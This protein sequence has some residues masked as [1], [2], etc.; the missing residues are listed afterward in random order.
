MQQDKAAEFST[1]LAADYS[2]A[3][4]S[5]DLVMKGG[6][7]SGV[8]YPTTMCRLAQK[9]RFRSIGGTSAGALAAALAAAAEHERGNAVG[10]SK[11]YRR[12]AAVPGYLGSGTNLRDLF[13]PSASTAP[14]FNLGMA[15]LEKPSIPAIV[16]AALR[17]YSGLTARAALAGG[18]ALALLL[19]LV[20]YIAFASNDPDPMRR[21]W[22]VGI[23]AVAAVCVSALVF[24]TLAA[25]LIGSRMM[26]AL[27][28][29]VPDNDF[30]FCTGLE[31][32][33]PG[34]PVPLTPWLGDRI[35]YIA[36]RTDVE[37]QPADSTLEPLTFGDLYGT[38]NPSHYPYPTGSPVLDA[39][40]A[41]SARRVN[42]EMVTTDVTAGRPYRLPFDADGVTQFFYDPVELARFFPARVLKRMRGT[43]PSVTI[44]VANPGNGGKPVA[45]AVVPFPDAP[46]LPVIVAARMSMSF[47]FLFSAVP[48]Y[49]VNR[50]AFASWSGAANE[51]PEFRKTWFSD[52]GLSSNIPIHFFDGPIPRWP[53]FA[54]NLRGF[55]RT[56]DG[57]VHPLDPATATEQQKVFLATAYDPDVE[58]F[59]LRGNG[60]MFQFVNSLLDSMRN[61]NDNTLMQLPSYRERTVEIAM[62]SS[63]GG[64]NLV[65]P[66]D[67]LQSIMKRGFY[68]AR[69]QRR[70]ERPPPHPPPHGAP[71]AV[72]VDAPLRRGLDHAGAALV[73]GPDR[74][75]GTAVHGG[76][77][78]K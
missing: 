32:P 73:L 71:D 52:G 40:N 74:R 64:L 1:L 29:D 2:Q 62:T 57:A 27:Q 41:L 55:P 43:A 77:R 78:S 42:L 5:C 44:D 54:L 21:N 69:R 36:G 46:D 17:Q 72:G 4:Q 13:Q 37:A 75:D 6:V 67:V 19:W 8:V 53:T 26:S 38:P 58:L 63:E 16:L 68:A 18:I 35:D 56:K 9:F 65:M 59:D 30:G 49:T 45:V 12:L 51:Q 47:P 22:I 3:D 76:L 61:W 15:W 70:M 31:T 34:A 39:L 11:G 7:T 60:R 50:A 10:S 48:L 23:A 20:G 24:A 66:E 25:F 14:L 28:S 33:R